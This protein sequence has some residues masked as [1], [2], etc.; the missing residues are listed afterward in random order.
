MRDMGLGRL[1]AVFGALGGLALMTI[2]ASAV[3]GAT[4][5]HH[6][7]TDPGTR[8]AHRPR[9]TPTPALCPGA[10]VSCPLSAP[11]LGPAKIAKLFYAY[12]GR[13]R[14]LHTRGLW[15]LNPR[16]NGIDP[17]NEGGTVTLTDDSGAIILGMSVASFQPAGANFTSVNDQGSVSVGKYTGKYLFQIQFTQ[18][19]FPPGFFR[20]RY[21]LCM[22]IGDDGFQD[23]IVCQPKPFGGFICHQ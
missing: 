1:V 3:S 9:Q 14:S 5:P 10:P 15:S 2:G 18:P 21:H 16:S 19:N 4:V 23:S 7:R 13:D 6:P 17:V 20:V 22:N 12:P 8:P 11:C